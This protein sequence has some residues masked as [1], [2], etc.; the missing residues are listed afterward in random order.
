MSLITI[1][2]ILPIIDLCI[3]EKIVLEKRWIREL[4][5]VIQVFIPTFL[6]FYLDP[7]CV[8]LPCIGFVGLLNVL[9]AFLRDIIV[10]PQ[11]YRDEKGG[12]I[13]IRGRLRWMLIAPLQAYSIVICFALLLLY[14]GNE[15]CPNISNHIT[16]LYQSALTFTTL[17][18]GDIKPIGDQGKLLV[19][20]ELLFFFLFI[21]LK[22][23][24][25]VSVIR[26]KST[27]EINNEKNVQHLNSADTKD[28]AAD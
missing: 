12:Y 14:F 21:G 10:A 24:I 23:P 25:A 8:L 5:V 17:G 3:P 6:L 26:V 13:L 7:A 19:I 1:L 27:T 28:R 11:K 20:L 2:S 9:S 4:Y 16:A 15:F 18:Y 22:L